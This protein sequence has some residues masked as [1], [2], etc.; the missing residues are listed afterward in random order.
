MRWDDMTPEER[1]AYVNQDVVEADKREI[2]GSDRLERVLDRNGALADLFQGIGHLDEDSAL[3]RQIDPM[4]MECLRLFHG[5][6][7]SYDEIAG[8]ME[9]RYVSCGRV[10]KSRKLSRHMIHKMLSSGREALARV[11]GK[12]ITKRRRKRNKEDD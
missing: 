1:D 11:Y 10:V 5:E 3:Y 12:D 4:E 2:P 7:M 9:M 6:G 8:H